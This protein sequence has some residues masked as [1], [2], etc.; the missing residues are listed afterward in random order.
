MQINDNHDNDIHNFSIE[1]KNKGHNDADDDD[2]FKVVI[3]TWAVSYNIN[4]NA[5]NC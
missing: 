2:K 5:C 3:A 4:H 1:S